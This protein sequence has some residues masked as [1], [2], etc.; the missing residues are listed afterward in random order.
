MLDPNY[1]YQQYGFGGWNGIADQWTS[2]STDNISVN[3]WMYPT[4]GQTTSAST[5][6]YTQQQQA[7]YQIQ[8]QNM[9]LQQ[10]ASSE[11]DVELSLLK[12]VRD[13]GGFYALI[14]LNEVGLAA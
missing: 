5:Y 6:T 11:R 14:L 1:P 4:N 9:L 10:V 7:Q 8:L 3:P 13:R 2:N 12:E